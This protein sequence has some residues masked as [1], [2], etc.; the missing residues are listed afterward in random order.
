MSP[1]GASQK[2]DNDGLPILSGLESASLTWVILRMRMSRRCYHVELNLTGP[3][4]S[5]SSGLL[6]RPS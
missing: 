1:P 3:Q 4:R 2:Y 6:L 5:S